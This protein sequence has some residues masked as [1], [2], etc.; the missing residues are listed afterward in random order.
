MRIAL[1]R[2]DSIGDVM[3]TL[4][5]AGY[6]KENI[7]SAY[8]FFV[9][10]SYTEH[11]IHSCHEIDKYLNWD[12]F[13]QRTE[14]ENI[15]FLKRLNLDVIIFVF[16]N[17]ELARLCKKANIGVRIGVNRRLKNW[18][19]CNTLVSFTR[20]GSDLHE[21]QLNFKL[22]KPIIENTHVSLDNIHEYNTFSAQSKIPNHILH[23]IDTKKKKVILHC[24]S[25]GSAREWGVNN[26]RKL[27]KKLSDSGYQVILTGT[28]KEGEL[29]RNEGGIDFPFVF[30]STG[31]LT[32]D[33][34]IAFI[35]QCD[36]LVAASTGPLHI[37][38]SLGIH[39]IGLYTDI[40]PIHPGRWQPIGKHVQVITEKNSTTTDPN[41][42][43][44]I[45][46][47]EVFNCIYSHCPT[48]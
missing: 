32:L 25:Q 40:K 30:D 1:S 16:P 44:D 28:Q 18:L 12:Q 31:K 20:K 35:A 24:K 41:V 42:L 37:A 21:S 2:T 23:E 43:L 13:D 34:L 14:Q 33:E 38:A 26:F 9:G 15:D 5:M 6:I 4:P 45:T 11:I 39:A 7:Q 36:C 19:Y 3:L 17:Y 8:I 47:D 22:L 27:A 29:I 48:K 46:V 10:K